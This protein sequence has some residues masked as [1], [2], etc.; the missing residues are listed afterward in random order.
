MTGFNRVW[1]SPETLPSK[2]EILDPP[3]WLARVH[4]E[5]TFSAGPEDL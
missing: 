4:P 5:P 1:T 3:L 2:A